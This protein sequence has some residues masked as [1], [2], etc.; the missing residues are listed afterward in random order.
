M[1][2]ET[3]N[4]RKA[5]IEELNKLTEKENELE[6]EQESTILKLANVRRRKELV[7]A[8][9]NENKITISEKNSQ[10]GNHIETKNAPDNLKCNRH[11]AADFAFEILSKRGKKPMHY[12]ELADLVRA[13][14][15]DL[16]TSNAPQTLV[17][18]MAK[19]GRFIRPA[20]RGWYSLREFY[21]KTKSVGSRKK[22]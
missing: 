9:L 11:S 22:K 15:A 1:N 10:N 13:K 4:L 21:P 12:K 20:K 16:G 2:S 3:N 19:D 7:S 8:L 14:G 17:A 6:K 5:L 18:R